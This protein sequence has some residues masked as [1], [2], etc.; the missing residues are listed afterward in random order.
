MREADSKKFPSK[1]WCSVRCWTC[2]ESVT[3]AIKR[4]GSACIFNKIQTCKMPSSF[5]SSSS[6]CIRRETASSHPTEK[7]VQLLQINQCQNKSYAI[8]G[9]FC[10][11]NYGSKHACQSLKCDLHAYCVAKQKSFIFWNNTMNVLTKY[12]MLTKHTGACHL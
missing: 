10:N 6:S 5:P 2:H 7:L 9:R 8:F 3:S 12:L 1:V 11:A 4:P